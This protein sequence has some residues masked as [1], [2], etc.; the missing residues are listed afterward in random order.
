MVK[1]SPA[2]DLEVDSVDRDDVAVALGQAG[3]AHV[4]RLRGAPAR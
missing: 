4:G 3:Q 1:N 2:L